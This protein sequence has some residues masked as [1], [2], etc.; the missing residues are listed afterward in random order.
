MRVALQ[1]AAVFARLGETSRWAQAQFV[2]G[3]IHFYAG[4]Y[5]AAR[6]ALA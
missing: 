4:R 6:D 2:I 3:G 1:A 5:E